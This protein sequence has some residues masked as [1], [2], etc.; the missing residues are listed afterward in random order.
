MTYDEMIAVIEA[1]KNGQE[2]EFSYK[3]E[4]NWKPRMYKGDFDFSVFEYRVKPQEIPE[5]KDYYLYIFS[6]GGTI[7]VSG[8]YYSSIE[9]ARRDTGAHINII[10]PALWSKLT[11]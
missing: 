4:G 8:N 2:I 10:G 7:S 3:E 1:E 9:E 11:Y 6:Y 5:T